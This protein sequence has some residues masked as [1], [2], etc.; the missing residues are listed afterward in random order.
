MISV[1]LMPFAFMSLYTAFQHP[2]GDHGYDVMRPALLQGEWTKLNISAISINEV[3]DE[4]VLRVS[5]FHNC[6]TICTRCTASPTLLR[7]S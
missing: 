7:A 3:A 2:A 5:D 4:V 6:A 1:I